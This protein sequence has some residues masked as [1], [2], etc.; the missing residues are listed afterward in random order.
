MM[1]DQVRVRASIRFLSAE[2]GGRASPLA[3]G[4]SYRPNHNFFGPN[5]RDMCMGFIE[6]PAGQ[7]VTPGETIQA[8]LDLLIYPAVKPEIKAG[9]QWRIQEGG[10]LVAVGTILEVLDPVC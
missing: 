9:K 5:D 7:Q 2:E 3:G 1:D 8:D 4:G 10:K 6:L